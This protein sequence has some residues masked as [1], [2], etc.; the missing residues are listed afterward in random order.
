MKTFPSV[1]D[2]TNKQTKAESMAQL[3]NVP[4]RIV[5]LM[6]DN[7]N[8]KHQFFFTN[9]DIKDGFW[10]LA[11][12][13]HD[14]WNFCFILAPLKGKSIDETEIIVPNCLQMGW[15]KSPPFSLRHDPKINR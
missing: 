15:C 5:E 11:V 13:N 6:V 8:K 14:A 2:V 4:Q 12:N 10:R 7:Y 9:L 3:E 1:N